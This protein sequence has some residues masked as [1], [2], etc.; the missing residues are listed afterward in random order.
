MQEA[1][2]AAD[3]LAGR[4]QLVKVPV[5]A[6]YLGVSASHLYDLITEDKLAGVVRI[7]RVIRIDLDALLA[8]N[9]EA[10]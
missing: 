2:E 9:R 3:D 10:S 7:G 5:A 1:V 4:P 6:K 8:A